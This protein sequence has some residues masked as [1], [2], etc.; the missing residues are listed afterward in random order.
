MKK[1][2]I[3]SAALSVVGLMLVSCST[4]EP[5][6]TTT[7]TRQTTVTTAAPPPTTGA[8]TTTTTTHVGPAATDCQSRSRLRLSQVRPCEGCLRIEQQM[9]CNRPQAGGVQVVT[10]SGFFRGRLCA[11]GFL[12]LHLTDYRRDCLKLFAIAKIH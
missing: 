10:R 4:G 3:L 8:R 7:T 12:F 5:E 1:G 6:A 2:M 9:N 11:L